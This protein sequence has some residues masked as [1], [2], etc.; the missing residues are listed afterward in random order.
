MLRCLIAVTILL[1]AHDTMAIEKPDYEVIWQG[2][3]FEIRR[4]APA[5]LAQTAVTG[6]FKQVGT[7]AFRKLGGYIF[8]QNVS[9]EKIAMTAPVTQSQ[10][11]SGDFLVSFY[12][13]SQHSLESLPIP[14]DQ[15]VTMVE[16]P[17]TYFAAR[18][19]RGGWSE[20][21]YNRQVG[22]LTADLALDVEWQAAG[23]PVWARYDPPMMP[24]FLRTNEVLIPVV[25]S[26][27]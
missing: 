22:Q 17:E 9:Q 24:S 14:N 25:P 12:M 7:A 23:S 18:R 26:T 1:C 2:E 6:S 3:T 13:P 19:Y 16:M 4:Y 20:K 10:R 27:P 21:K 11:E 15:A 8:G 5:I